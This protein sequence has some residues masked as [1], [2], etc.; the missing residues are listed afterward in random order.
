[1]LS[2]KRIAMLVAVF[3][4]AIFIADSAAQAE[5][6]KINFGYRLTMV[7]MILLQG[8]FI[9]KYDLEMDSKLFTTGIEMREGII[10]EKVHIGEVGI[11]PTSVALTRAGEG[12]Q[13]V[14]VSE[15]GGGKYRVMVKTDSP[16][17]SIKDLVGKKV[18]IKIG[19]GCYVA[20]LLYIDKHG[21]KEKDFKIL[22]SG[23]QEAIAAMEEGSIDAVIYWEPVVSVLEAK[24]IAKELANFSEVVR[25]PVFLITQKKFADNN[26][27]ALVKF[28]AAFADAQELIMT[29]RSTAAD[30]V[31]KS[32]ASHGQKTDKAVY[33]KAL[34]HSVYEPYLKPMLIE[35]LK[36]NWQTLVQ[37]GKLKGNE[38][39]WNGIIHPEYLEEAMKLRG[40]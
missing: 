24:G 32:L 23:D 9:E 31:V 3:V 27:S 37:K 20:F 14:G 39:D 13:V 18:A 26:R 21:L 8:K 19:S 6:D 5:T 25:N 35:D 28:L 7:S 11:T 22:N 17:K 12:L 16:Y 33:E 15:W 36:E 30:M 34:S 1:M 10:T 40:K 29:D 38:P 4:I 2:N